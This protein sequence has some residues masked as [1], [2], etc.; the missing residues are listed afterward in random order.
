MYIG[1]VLGNNDKMARAKTNKAWH[2][3]KTR[4]NRHLF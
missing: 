4:R 2:T 1:Q 3:Q